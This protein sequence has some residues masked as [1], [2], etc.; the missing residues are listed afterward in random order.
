M[1]ENNSLLRVVPIFNMT[2]V[3]SFLI[4]RIVVEVPGRKYQNDDDRKG[5]VKTKKSEMLGLEVSKT[6]IA[7]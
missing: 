3:M 7:S 2:V 6:L 1:N 5:K 4:W